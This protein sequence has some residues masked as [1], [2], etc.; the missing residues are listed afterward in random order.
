MKF[1]MYY[2]SR[3]R[4][5]VYPPKLYEC[6]VSTFGE[7]LCTFG[8]MT[9]PEE[10]MENLQDD[11]YNTEDPLFWKEYFQTEQEENA[12]SFFGQLG[13]DYPWTWID[14]DHWYPGRKN[15]PTA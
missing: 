14:L 9:T 8:Y 11:G 10:G 12:V 3:D 6:N 15:E 5:N 7:A 4:F 13:D 1:L 2:E